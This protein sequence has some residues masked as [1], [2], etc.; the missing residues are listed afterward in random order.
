MFT[1]EPVWSLRRALGAIRQWLWYQ[2]REPVVEVPLWL[3]LRYHH[4]PQ[5]SHRDGVY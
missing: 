4:R 5:A 1:D 2:T 3:L